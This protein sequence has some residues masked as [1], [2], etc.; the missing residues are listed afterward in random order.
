MT[1]KIKLQVAS[2]RLPV[3]QQNRAIRETFN[4]QPATCNDHPAFS[5]IEVLV[6]VSL[7]SVIVLV[8]R[9]TSCFTLRSRPPL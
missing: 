5:L 1:V 7:L 3:L 6:V 2:R 8:T 4:F 9:W